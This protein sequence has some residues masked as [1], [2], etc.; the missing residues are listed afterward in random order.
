MRAVST[1]NM[2]LVLMNSR[3]KLAL[4]DP[5]VRRRALISHALSAH[6]IHVEPFETIDELLIAVTCFDGVLLYDQK[7]AVKRFLEL[8]T[9]QGRCNLIIGFCEDPSPR[10]IV[11][12][13]LAGAIDY[14][15]WPFDAEELDAALAGVEKSRKHHETKELRTVTVRSHLNRLTRREL[16]VLDGLTRGLANR[17]IAEELGIS[18]RTVETHR[19]NILIKLGAK[20]T[21]EAIRLTS[22]VASSS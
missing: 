6:Q 14:I 9:E 19:A 7:G 3:V 11:D 2:Y 18:R 1:W 20:N 16:E 17:L 15:V 5:S 10:Q 8:L 4:V 22:E 21:S 13:I 12:A